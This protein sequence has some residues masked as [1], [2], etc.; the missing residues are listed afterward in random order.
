MMI[1][2]KVVAGDFQFDGRTLKDRMP[3]IVEDGVLRKL[4]GDLYF[5]PKGGGTPVILSGSSEGWF[6]LKHGQFHSEWKRNTLEAFGKPTW[7]LVECE[8]LESDL[9]V[10]KREVRGCCQAVLSKGNPRKVDLISVTPQ[11]QPRDLEM[12]LAAVMME[13]GLD[14]CSDLAGI[15]DA[16]WGYS[17]PSEL[18]SKMYEVFSSGDGNEEPLHRRLEFRHKDVWVTVGLLN[19]AQNCGLS[20]HLRSRTEPG[21]FMPFALVPNLTKLE[22]PFLPALMLLKRHGW[23]A[24][25]PFLDE[26][27]VETLSTFD[28]GVRAAA[29]LLASRYQIE[30]VPDSTGHN[31]HRFA[32]KAIASGAALESRV[33]MSEVELRSS[34]VDFA[35]AYS[36]W[37]DQFISEMV[38][39]SRISECVWIPRQ[40][41]VGQLMRGADAVIETQ[42]DGVEIPIG[43]ADRLIT[44]TAWNFE[45]SEN[46]ADQ[47]RYQPGDFVKV[48]GF[49]APPLSSLGFVSI[50]DGTA[51]IVRPARPALVTAIV[52]TTTGLQ[53]RA[54]TVGPDGTIQSLSRNEV[55]HRFCFV[56]QIGAV[57]SV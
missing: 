49:L 33:F 24:F 18:L 39:A 16:Y 45:E 14:Q 3:E 17:N 9:G 28:R 27:H 57:L 2:V 51:L 5:S 56:Q 31:K 6:V 40:A 48:V 13:R 47:D 21:H 4:N 11:C 41:T 7:L 55:P 38:A 44:I 26:R 23:K 34:S 43:R 22:G 36:L 1:V 12:L 15:A 35:T 32:I 30:Y 37:G 10:Q 8:R 19:P 50:T 46:L 25:E 54:I 42:R 52:E 53:I 29:V 20:I